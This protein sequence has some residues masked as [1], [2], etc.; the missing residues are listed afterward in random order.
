L[1]PLVSAAVGLALSLAFLWGSMQTAGLSRMP[2]AYTD[3]VQMWA[4][5]QFLLG[6]TFAA[7]SVVAL[8]KALGPASKLVAVLT[9]LV[10]GFA[11]VVALYGLLAAIAVLAGADQHLYQGAAVPILV[12][13]AAIAG[14]LYWW[15]VQRAGVGIAGALPGLLLVLTYT[16]SFFLGAILF[17]G[18]FTPN[19]RCI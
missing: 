17:C 11:A 10:A 19:I 9:A 18:L 5:F 2:G 12:G 13:V 7:A 1:T 16:P 6:G 8:L 3:N 4:Y 14:A 15:I